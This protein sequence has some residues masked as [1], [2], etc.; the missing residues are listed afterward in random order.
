MER[1]SGFSGV[2]V[3]YVAPSW[4]AASVGWASVMAWAICSDGEM[5]TGAFSERTDMAAVLTFGTY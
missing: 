2:L 5:L 1:W 4:S 3:E